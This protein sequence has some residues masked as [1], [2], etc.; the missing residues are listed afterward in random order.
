M[1]VTIRK[2]TAE[3]RALIRP[4]Q[5]EIALLH[6]NGRPDM[7]KK[8]ARYFTEEA[9]Q[10]RLK[11]PKHT[12]LIAETEDGSVVGYAFAWIISNRNHPTYLDF[13]VFYIDDIC[14]LEHCQRLGIGQ[15]LFDRCKAIAVERGCKNIDLGVWSFNK[16]AIAF[17][18]HCG[19][20]ERVRR[21]ELSLEG[22]TCS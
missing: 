3:D 1:T 2:A 10:Q 11:D 4:L 19:M 14:V 22:K 7:F 9:F 17:Y 13:D 16:N 21:M 18:E 12:V 15:M 20:K 5:E 8:D 6:H